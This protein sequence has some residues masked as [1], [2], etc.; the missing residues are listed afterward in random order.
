MCSNL[1]EYHAKCAGHLVTQSLHKLPCVFMNPCHIIF[2]AFI[3][4]V[5]HL[6]VNMVDQCTFGSHIPLLQNLC[7]HLNLWNQQVGETLF[8]NSIILKLFNW[9][10]E[11]LLNCY[12]YC[13]VSLQQSLLQ[14]FYYRLNDKNL[15]ISSL[16]E[17]TFSSFNCWSGAQWEGKLSRKIGEYK[18]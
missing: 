6:N 9:G 12:K 8:A 7:L 11:T 17:Y 1:D 3:I 15:H 13:F 18:A 14:K 2:L 5:T 4:Y 16:I 10:H